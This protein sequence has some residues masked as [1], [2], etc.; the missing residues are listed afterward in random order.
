VLPAHVP[1]PV[2]S[3]KEHQ[4]VLS[5]LGPA[6]VDLDAILHVTGL[7]PRAVQ[8]ALMELDLAGLISRPGTGLIAR[9]S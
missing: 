9:Q 6:P 3:E 4:L 8:I 1:P 2:V 5:A 7:S